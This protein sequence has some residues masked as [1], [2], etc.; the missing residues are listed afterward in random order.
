M[1]EFTMLIESFSIQ[2]ISHDCFGQKQNPTIKQS[3]KIKDQIKR[4]V[5]KLKRRRT[6]KQQLQEEKVCLE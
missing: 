5:I 4:K 2:M 3:G 6:R 1:I